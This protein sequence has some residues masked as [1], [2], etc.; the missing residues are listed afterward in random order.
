[1]A[2]STSLILDGHLGELPRLATETARFCR[3]Q[4]LGADV[5]F[6]LNLV[7]EELFT[8]AVRHGDCGGVLGAAEVRL[9]MLANGVRVEYADCGTPF[10]PL[11]APPPDV[12]VPLEE[13]RMGGL[14]IHLVRQIMRDFEYQRSGGWNRSR[15][16][17]PIPGDEP[18]G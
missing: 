3:E 11:S 6:D 13:R 16:R 18:K 1:M 5:E 2:Q 9:A 14:G 4:G 12:T 17:R 15:M 10:E 7:L 8:N